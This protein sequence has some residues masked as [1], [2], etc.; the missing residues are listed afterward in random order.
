MVHSAP[1]NKIISTSMATSKRAIV[2]TYVEI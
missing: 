1:P 2:K